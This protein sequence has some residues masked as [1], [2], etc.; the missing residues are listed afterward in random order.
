MTVLIPPR[1]IRHRPVARMAQCHAVCALAGGGGARREV[2]EVLATQATKARLKLDVACGG[3]G[4]PTRI[5]IKGVLTDTGAIP[6]ASIVETLFYC[7]A[8]AGLPVNVPDC[9]HASLNA[10][11]SRGAIVMRDV[12][13]AGGRFCNALEPFTPGAAGDGL[14]QLARLHIASQP[15]S[16]A[17]G[18]GWARSFIDQISRQPIIPHDALQALLF[19]LL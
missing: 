6:S 4:V 12:I 17:F 14:D 3:D 13:A 9:I 19:A 8:A 18:F 2:I 5:C 15:G 7:E 16:A 10:D 1:L 11:G